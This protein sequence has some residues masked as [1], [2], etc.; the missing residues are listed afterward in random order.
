MFVLSCYHVQP[1]CPVIRII[2]VTRCQ[3]ASALHN[4]KRSPAELVCR[5]YA[6]EMRSLIDTRTRQFSPIHR[7]NDRPETIA[8]TRGHVRIAQDI[9]ACVISRISNRPVAHDIT[10]SLGAIASV[11]GIVRKMSVRWPKLTRRRPRM[12]WLLSTIV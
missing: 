7:V 3:L 2:S 5:L 9:I 11:I 1:S 6:S 4:S 12:L 8:Y 10:V